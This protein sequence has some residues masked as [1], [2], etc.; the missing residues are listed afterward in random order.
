MNIDIENYI[1]KHLEE[2]DIAE[3]V[4]R[5]LRAMVADEFKSTVAPAVRKEIDTIIKTE[6]EVCFSKPIKTD[7]GW[8]ERKEYASLDDLFKLELYKRLES[9]YEMKSTIKKLVEAKVS[10]LM[11][12]HYDAITKKMAN[13]LTKAAS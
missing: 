9:S 3:L 10:D 4:R 1:Q 13:E 6:L 11:K 5:E 2:M 7:N 12:Q 8:G